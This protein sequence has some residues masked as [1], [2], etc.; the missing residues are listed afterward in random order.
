MQDLIKLKPCFDCAK[1]D[2]FWESI[3]VTCRVI[4]SPGSD[5]GGNPDGKSDDGKS[6]G[7]GN[8]DK[9]DDGV[10]DGNGKSFG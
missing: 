10:K 5:G 7:G 6:G 1:I 3:Q 9:V 4:G 2:G 8:D